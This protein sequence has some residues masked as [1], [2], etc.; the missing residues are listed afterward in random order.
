MSSDL[1]HQIARETAAAQLLL[2]SL[3]DI[4]LDEE[5]KATAIE[6]ET[7]LAETVAAAVDRLEE[8]KTLQEAIKERVDRLKHRAARLEQQREAIRNAL[9]SML[10]TTGLAKVETPAGTVGQRRVPPSVVVVDE[11]QIPADYLKPQPPKIDVKGIAQALKDGKIVTG[12]QLSNGGQTV[13]IW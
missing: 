6:G 10:E 1:T 8:I 4:D 12:A 5:D 11:T 13:A 9:R 3:R 2:S 7:S